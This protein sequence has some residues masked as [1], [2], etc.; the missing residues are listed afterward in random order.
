AAPARGSGWRGRGTPRQAGGGGYGV[1]GGFLGGGPGATHRPSLARSFPGAGPPGGE[2]SSTR[3]LS[4]LHHSRKRTRAD[5]WQVCS[6]RPFWPPK[7]RPICSLARE[8]TLSI[9]SS[10]PRC[11]E[12]EET[13]PTCRFLSRFKG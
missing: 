13:T 10:T 8:V 5:S 7:R 3:H 12:R 2:G 11:F 9:R 4:L 1:G 6:R